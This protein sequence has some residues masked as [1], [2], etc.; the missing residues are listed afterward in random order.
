MVDLL[1]I[2]RLTKPNPSGQE[3]L[4]Y[5]RSIKPP[6]FYLTE[7]SKSNLTGLFWT[8]DLYIIIYA[9]TSDTE[10]L[11]SILSEPLRGT[12]AHAFT[13]QQTSEFQ[14]QSLAH[15][16]NPLLKTN[17]TTWLSHWHNGKF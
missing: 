11:K 8:K 9:K 12:C 17:A 3:L 7:Y 2:G 1:P 6:I 16:A 15:S 5:S 14:S 13:K 10:S 4:G